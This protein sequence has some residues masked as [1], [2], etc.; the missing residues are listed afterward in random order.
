MKR[1]RLSQTGR[2]A[3]PRWHF[4]FSLLSLALFGPGAFSSLSGVSSLFDISFL[5]EWSGK[6]AVSICF[7]AM[8]QNIWN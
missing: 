8:Q 7:A 6:T 1:F 4:L 5:D 2:E 3:R